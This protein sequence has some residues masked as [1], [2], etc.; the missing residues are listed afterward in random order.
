MLAVAPDLR[1]HGESDWAN[2]PEY[3]CAEYA[4]DIAALI[5]ALS[6][7][8]VSIVAHSMSVYHTLRHAAARPDGLKSI[9][10]VD[11][12]PTGRPEHREILRA[13]G[14]KPERRFQSVAEAVERERRIMPSADGNLLSEFVRHNLRPVD[15]DSYLTY[16][17]DPA[18]LAQF[19][20]Y[21]EWDKL[22]RIPCPV[23]VVYGSDSPLVSS[24]TMRRVADELP[25]G[26]LASV[27]GGHLPHLENSRA[28]TQLV[29]E[30][31]LA[32]SNGHARARKVV[33]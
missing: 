26:Q 27:P 15:A 32:D 13:A 33:E 21:D 9:I 22:A 11:I 6:L 3:G 2:P 1:G 20:Y 12:E 18:T 4:A 14:R 10:L 23:L 5:E 7:T 8:Q 29:L 16:R 30:F 24:D 25:L 19:D 28:F 17:Y 31:L